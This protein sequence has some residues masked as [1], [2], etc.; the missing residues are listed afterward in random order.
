MRAHHRAAALLVG[1]G[2]LLPSLVLADPRSPVQG[3]PTATLPRIAPARPE[4]SVTVEVARPDSALRNLLNARLTPRHFQIEGV[5]TLPFAE[6]AAQFAPLANQEITIAQLLEA[7]NAVTKMYEARGYP[8]SFA[9]VPAQDFENGNVLITVVEGYVAKIT[10]NGTPGPAEK[11]LRAIADR[12]AQDRPL[13]RQTF[14]RYVNVLSQQPGMQVAAT[15]QPPQTTDG[16]CEMVLDVKRKPFAFG[17]A[18]DYMSPGFRAI[19]T[20]TTNSL[21]PLSEQISVS[22]LF[23]KGRDSEEYYAASYAQPIGTEGMLARLTASHY[24]GVPQNATLE[25]L[26]FNPRYVNDTKRIGGQLGYPLLLSNAHSLTLT[27]GLYGADQFERYTH[28]ATGTP[29]TLGTHVRV[30]TAELTYVQRREGQTRNAL[31]GLYKGFD[32]LGASRQNN[33]NDLDF[34]R[35]RLLVSQ[36]NDLPFGFGTNLSAAGQYSANRLASGEQIS[37]G[38]RFFGLGYPAGEVAGDKG[39]GA[40]AELNHLFLP[41]LAYLRTVQPYLW[42]DVARVYSNSAS[43]SHRKLSSVA[44]GVRLSDRKYY[45]L[46]LSVAQPVGDKPTNA[47]HR[48]PRINMTYSYQFD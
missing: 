47:T 3:D 42:V 44:L 13:R 15:V 17:T 35:T 43:L 48:S 16:A 8:L 1:V 39:W 45:T 24:R 22:A 25:P 19:A 5:K 10:V 2:A 33:A 26:G 9:F 41:D 21:T 37:F 28:A 11:R 38:G 34:W 46:D 31:L 29:V 27:G 20:A 4:S 6:I 30:G 36:A 7:A 14:E 40:A 12:L 32:A 23:P 18:I